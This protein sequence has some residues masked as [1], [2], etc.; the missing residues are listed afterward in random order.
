[1]SALIEPFEHLEGNRPLKSA[2][3]VP[4][5]FLIIEINPDHPSMRASWLVPIIWLDKRR[6]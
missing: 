2:S 4:K 6:V 3:K 5:P 1:M